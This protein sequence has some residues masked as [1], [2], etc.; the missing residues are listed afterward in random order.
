EEGTVYYFW[1]R[2]NCGTLAGESFWTGPLTFWTPQVAVTLPYEQDFEDDTV[3]EMMLFSGTQAN[4]WVVGTAT[5]SSPTHSSYVSFDGTGNTYTGT[6]SIVH[7]YRT[8]MVP[9]GTTE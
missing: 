8:F 7:T 2:G 3:P 5:S 6:T 1:V 9:A 4:K